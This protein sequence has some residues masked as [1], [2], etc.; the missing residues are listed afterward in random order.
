MRLSYPMEKK[1]QVAENSQELKMVQSAHPIR[2]RRVISQSHF[3][4]QIDPRGNW[5]RKVTHYDGLRGQSR[6]NSADMT[7]ICNPLIIN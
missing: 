1:W 7:P 3:S 6:I 5:A 2:R 4:T